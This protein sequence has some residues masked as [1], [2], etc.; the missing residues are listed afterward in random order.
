MLA[1]NTL[2]DVFKLSLHEDYVDITLV[3]ELCEFPLAS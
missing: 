3:H 2:N 1:V